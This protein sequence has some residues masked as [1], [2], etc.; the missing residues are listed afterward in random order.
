[1]IDEDLIRLFEQLLKL[2]D[3]Y[4]IIIGDFHCVAAELRMAIRDAVRW[5]LTGAG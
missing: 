2:E 4:D 3:N 1:M 5:R